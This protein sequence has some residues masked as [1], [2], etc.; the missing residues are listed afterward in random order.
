MPDFNK[1]LQ[2]STAWS[3]LMDT[4]VFIPINDP[5]YFICKFNDFLKF[6]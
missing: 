6:Q 3:N 4:I 1:I 5:Q 2:M